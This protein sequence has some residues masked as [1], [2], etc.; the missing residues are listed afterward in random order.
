MTDFGMAR[1]RD[2]NP[3]ASCLTF[4]MCPGADV[5]IAP[6]A[7]QDQPVTKESGVTEDD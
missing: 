2:I 7:I 3:R 4:T 6:E 5:Y 1:I